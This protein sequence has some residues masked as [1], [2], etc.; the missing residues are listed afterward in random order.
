[1]ERETLERLAMDRAFGE[2]DADTTAL[3]DAYLA[4]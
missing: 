4:D 2:L 3:F 1:M